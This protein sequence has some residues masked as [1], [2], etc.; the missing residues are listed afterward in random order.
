MLG[1]SASLG[2]GWR[3]GGKM[4]NEPATERGAGVSSQ[5]VF[6]GFLF[7]YLAGHNDYIHHGDLS[8]VYLF[9]YLESG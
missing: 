9:I 8:S 3:D 4:K 6:V 5:L 1:H 7:V 2:L